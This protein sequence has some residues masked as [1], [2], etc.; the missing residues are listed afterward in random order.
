MRFLLILAGAAVGAV[1]GWLLY[2]YV[3]CS[4][5]ACPMTGNKWLTPL[6]WALIG[7]Y[8]ASGINGGGA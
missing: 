3:G 5:G 6:L 4:G 8:A 7:A 1:T 2:R